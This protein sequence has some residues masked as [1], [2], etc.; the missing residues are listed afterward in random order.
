[1]LDYDRERIDGWFQGAI[2]AGRTEFT[3]AFRSGT[4]GHRVTILPDRIVTRLRT[5]GLSQLPIGTILAISTFESGF[6]EPSLGVLFETSVGSTAYRFDEEE[7]RRAFIGA[8]RQRWNPGN[9]AEAGYSAQVAD[10]PRADA[11]H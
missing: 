7:A 5:G 9:L 2:E 3:T 1:M 8:V 11:H 4:G 6:A 10:P